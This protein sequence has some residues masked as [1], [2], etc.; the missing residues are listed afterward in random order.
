MNQKNNLLLGR[1]IFTLFIILSLG[2]IVMN[3]KGKELFLPKIESKINDYITNN[4]ESIQSSIINHKITYSNDNHF[5]MKISSKNN[6]QHF[7]YIKYYRG[8]ITDTYQKDYLE[9]YNILKHI[10]K[11]LE[12][13][14]KETTNVECEIHALNKLNDYSK[15]VQEQ[16]IEEKNLKSLKFYSLEKEIII[17]SFNQKEITNQI[18]LMIN[19]MEENTI[20]P[21]Y[22]TFIITDKNDITNSIEIT[23]LTNSFITNNQNEEI[24][25]DIIENNNS[26]LL[27]KNKITYK[28]LN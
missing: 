27:Q 12:K 24:I 10:E 7:F 21:K 18:I 3:E 19:K 22:Y 28:Y 4:Y 5:K 17:D 1:A 25:H 26:E 11:S 14:I 6:K 23:H 16:L 9:G 20:T 2:L 13:E 15:K 8:N